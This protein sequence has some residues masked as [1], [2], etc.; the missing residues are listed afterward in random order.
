MERYSRQ[1]LFDGI[2]DEGQRR[3]GAARVLVV[4]CGALGSAQI[5]M[6]ARAGV[7]RLRVVDRDFV[8]ESN[9]QRQTMFTERDARERAPKAVAAARRVAEINSDVECEAEV[10]DVNQS[11]VEKLIKGCDVVLDGT[12]NFA[13]RFLLNDACVKRDVAWVYGAAV[14]SYGVTMTIRPRVTPCLRCVFPSVPAA[15][16]APTC[17]TAGVIIPII[18][19]V[20]SVQVTEA[21]KLLTSKVES[22]HGGLMRFDVWRNEWRRISTGER[23]QEC[24]TC[25]LGRFESLEAEAGDLA[26][27]LC[28]RDAVQVSPRG[29]VGASIDLDALAARL[30]AA[31]EVKSN[32]YL[33]RLRT[34]E[35]ELTVFRD[36]RAIVRGTDDATV[37]RSVYAR[38]VGT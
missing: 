26:T 2:G 38:Y 20:A 17:D 22:L 27:V 9:L 10:T 23:A 5:E 29:G 28:G 37:A 4:G 3:L 12:D 36:A 21:L 30:S 19:V 33:V 14:G 32:E 31:G 34:G 24:P 18:L 35:Y 25:A 16:S 6:L 15:G 11:N 13:T 7:G 8:E 1:I